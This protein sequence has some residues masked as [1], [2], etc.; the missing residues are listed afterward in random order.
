[1]GS[2]V[3]E[4]VSLGSRFIPNKD[5]GNALGIELL[6]LFVVYPCA[7]T[8]GSE[9]CH[10]RDLSCEDFVGCAPVQSSS[11][12]AVHDVDPDQTRMSRIFV[13]APANGTPS[14]IG[15][16]NC[17]SQKEFI[18]SQPMPILRRLQID[19]ACYDGED[20]ARVENSLPRSLTSVTS[21][22]INNAGLI[23]LHVPHLT[24]FKFL[25]GEEETMIDPLL[26][27]LDNCPLL[28]DLYTE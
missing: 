4:A 6:A 10:V 23:T 14:L 20:D 8:E 27:F 17:A 18:F 25:H 2:W 16:C 22:T 9:V 24:R 21:L 12:Y 7:T 3:P 11:Q 5:H 1:M 13:A 19:D 15:M 28:E 26:G